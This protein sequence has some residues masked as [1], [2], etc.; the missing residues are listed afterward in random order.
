MTWHESDA[1][2]ASTGT[3]HAVGEG[4]VR[5]YISHGANSGGHIDGPPWVDWFIVEPRHDPERQVESLRNG[6][7][8]VIA[9]D[10]EP[11][12]GVDP[13]L[14]RGLDKARE[15]GRF[16]IDHP[17]AAHPNMITD[18]ETRLALALLELWGVEGGECSHGHGF[19][20][21]CPE[22]EDCEW[23]HLRPALREALTLIP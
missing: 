19:E 4:R 14:S 12:Y 11:Y 2:H 16:F 22:G 18:R 23:Q 17:E 21:D 15:I 20:E 8:T 6:G 3:R 13:K 1:M 10:V 5:L 9:L 7:R